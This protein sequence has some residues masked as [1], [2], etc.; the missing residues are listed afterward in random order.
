MSRPAAVFPF[1]LRWNPDQ[2]A[3]A[4]PR[5]ARIDAVALCIS[6]GAT[7]PRD[8]RTHRRWR[9]AYAPRAA[10]THLFRIQG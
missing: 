7:A 9:T 10:A 6:A 1:D 3:E 5:R 2:L 4:M 8:A